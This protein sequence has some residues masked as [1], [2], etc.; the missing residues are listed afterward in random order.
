MAQ[1]AAADH[2]A[3]HHSARA[4]TASAF[5][6]FATKCHDKGRAPCPGVGHP[7]EEVA[8]QHSGGAPG[9]KR[10]EQVRAQLTQN[11]SGRNESRDSRSSIRIAPGRS[12][13][14][15]TKSKSR[16]C[17]GRTLSLRRGR[18]ASPYFHNRIR[19][20]RRMS[21]RIGFPSSERVCRALGAPER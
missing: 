1:T 15:R 9:E 4:M 14:L 11:F 16:L 8:T 3:S 6:D 7:V 20:C 10:L 18:T 12:I 5:R 19:L 2:S 21:Y 17:N 13:P